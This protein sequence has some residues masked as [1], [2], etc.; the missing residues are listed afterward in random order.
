MKRAI[1][2]AAV[3]AMLFSVTSCSKNGDSI[4]SSDITASTSENTLMYF[5]EDSSREIKNSATALINIQIDE[6]GKATIDISSW[7]I[8]E[9]YDLFREYFFGEWNNSDSVFGGQFIIDD[10]EKAY[11]SVNNHYFRFNNFYKVSENVV[12][13]T[14]DGNAET[15]MFWLDKTAPGTMYY[16][17]F[18]GDWLYDFSENQSVVC[19][20]KA[21]IQTNTPENG[22]LSVYRL[23]EMSRDYGI[24]WNMLTDIVYEAEGNSDKLYHDDWYQFYP[25]YLVSEAADKLTLET[26]VGNIMTNERE[27]RTE[28]TIEKIGDEWTRTI[29][30]F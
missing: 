3:F 10:S 22:F 2:I 6:N 11:L 30:F 25:V 13:F 23:R 12:A 19:F 24:P 17:P 8:S 28:Y 4:G 18:N 9:D 7:E 1:F 16:A 21:N 15:E 20:T 26:N 29:E 5:T 14:L 27:I